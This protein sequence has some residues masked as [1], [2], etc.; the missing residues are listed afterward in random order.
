M[1]TRIQ[2]LLS[3]VVLL[4]LSS[5][6]SAYYVFSE[7][8]G[9][10]N[11][12][13]KATNVPVFDLCLTNNVFH[14]MQTENLSTSWGDPVLHLLRFEEGA[15][16]EV[17]YNDDTG[18]GNNSMVG[19]Y[20]SPGGAGCT[21]HKLIIRAYDN[22]SGGNGGVN[23]DLRVD[24]VYRGRYRLG[25]FQINPVT[26]P[27]VSETMETVLVNNGTSGTKLLRFEWDTKS[28]HYQFGA[29]DYSAGLGGS[30]LLA[31]S[32][33]TDELWVVAT[34]Y[35]T[36]IDDSGS[37]R[38]LRNDRGVS[39]ADNDGLGDGLEY[40]LGTCPGANFTYS[41]CSGL[42]DPK[43]T[44]GD[45]LSDKHEAIGVKNGGMPVQLLYRWG[46][47]PVRKD[48]FVEVDRRSGTGTNGAPAPFMSE[49]AAIFAAQRYSR[50]NLI[51]NP[52]GSTG[53]SV[54]FDTGV[55]CDD[56]GNDGITDVCGNFG[57]SNLKPAIPEGEKW[58]YDGTDEMHPVREGIFHYATAEAGEGGQ[59]PLGENC[60]NFNAD[61]AVGPTVAHELGHN[62][63]LK[64]WGADSAGMMNNKLNY[65]SLMNY[66]YSNTYMNVQD[67]IKFSPGV[68]PD[69]LPRVLFENANFAGPDERAPH[70]LI[71]PWNF[72]ETAI[73]AEDLDWNRDGHWDPS[74]RAHVGHAP[75]RSGYGGDELPMV[76]GQHNVEGVAT[77][78]GAGAAYF[79]LPNDRESTWVFVNKNHSSDTEIHYNILSANGSSLS[80]SLWNPDGW[81]DANAPG[82]P[83][84][85][86][87]PEAVEFVRDGTRE[88]M[89]FFAPDNLRKIFFAG[90]DPDWNQ[91]AWDSI[92]NPAGVEFLSVSAAVMD[93]RLH[94]VARDEQSVQG[95]IWNGYFQSDG[96]WTGWLKSP[97]A[98][99][100]AD[101]VRSD[102]TPALVAAPD[103]KF[104]MFAVVA[105]LLK[106]YWSYDPA[107]GS[108]WW[109]LDDVADGFVIDDHQNCEIAGRIGATYRNHVTAS[110]IDLP[111]ERGAFWLWYG[112]QC[113]EDEGG[114]TVLK[115][116]TY[117]R[118]SRGGFDNTGPQ[119]DF[120]IGKWTYTPFPSSVGVCHEDE[121]LGARV[122]LVSG[123]DNMSAILVSDDQSK[124]PS[125]VVRVPFADGLA[126]VRIGD[127]NDHAAIE[128]GLC[129]S[130][131]TG[132]VSCET[133]FPN[134]QV[135]E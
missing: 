102:F 125:S 16:T 67:N 24:G 51:D 117:S 86:S 79:Q 63:G 72:V 58:Y 124:C 27:S 132:Y 13:T 11:G 68:L 46:A 113:P 29:M 71:A 80:T 77:D 97:R 43:D 88:M 64:H 69:V 38:V 61:S 108:Y 109:L 59:A 103:G 73:F 133:N 76:L 35:S 129:A 54:H 87:E 48:V 118:V 32:S 83:H 65:P 20:Y 123:P 85:D 70:L 18:S 4:S 128:V 42:F 135:C 3:L 120:T 37:V 75:N 130:L 47:S 10:T 62:M 41:Q 74:V 126:P 101:L 22:P 19:V 114:V 2:I 14:V 33:S 91:S 98:P 96:T 44:D 66:L 8:T 127:H 25:G 21:L 94:L 39:D 92:E 107:G 90:W 89:V 52:D 45:G 131:H 116:N 78:V 105:G 56:G 34:K 55:L 40:G 82:W 12:D 6:S 84:A 115:N 111:N 15:W 119:D 57:G 134:E 121:I 95:Q 112:V 99:A 31:G 1:Q 17:A 60:F 104:Y 50:L 23:F 49:S 36:A 9:V 81:L 53:V 28:G 100:G 26:A 93:G 5:S 122:A 30:S 7:E 110:G 106:T